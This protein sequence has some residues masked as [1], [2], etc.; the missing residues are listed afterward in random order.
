MPNQGASLP[1]KMSSHRPL[2]SASL[3]DLKQPV[4]TGLVSVV[5]PTY[6]RGRLIAR[7]IESALAQTYRNVSVVVVD[8]GS[9]DDTRKVVDSYGGCVSYVHQQ[10]AGVSSARNT[11][12]RCARGEFIA[13]LDSDDEWQ[14]WKIDAEVAALTSYPEA[15][16]VWTDMQSVDE[17]GTVVNAR[18]LRAMYGAY[19]KVDLERTLPKVNWLATIAER[20]GLH[21]AFAFPIPVADGL[22]TSGRLP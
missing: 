10:N 14:P 6:N 8:D 21:G 7:A 15:G 4:E 19:A 11:G 5:I 16:I 1:G 3:I 17:A 12:L 18:H 22:P 13:F 20:V 9:T 2:R